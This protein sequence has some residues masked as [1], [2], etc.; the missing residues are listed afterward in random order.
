MRLITLFTSTML[1]TALAFGSTATAQSAPQGDSAVPEYTLTTDF[2]DKWEAVA[3]DPSAPICNLM[4]MNLKSTTAQAA[5]AEYDAR[6]GNH[7]YLA[8][9]GLSARD[10]V[11]G[12][13]TL[14][15]AAMQE[16]QGQHPEMGAG[17]PVRQVSAQNM[18]FYQS[19]K[20]GIHEVMQQAGKARMQR[21]GGKL[22]NC[23]E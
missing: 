12:T 7:A 16:M 9:H 18:A 8:S 11:L 13:A 10:M 5:I 4:T 6:P 15:A 22:P 19:H 3:N 17:K 1:T 2:V 23:A 14:A 21:N 20:D